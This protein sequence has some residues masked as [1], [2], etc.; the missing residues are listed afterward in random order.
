V[1]TNLEESNLMLELGIRCIRLIRL[2]GEMVEQM[3]TSQ[4]GFRLRDELGSFHRLA[5]PEGCA[6]DCDSDALCF[7]GIGWVLVIWRES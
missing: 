6:V 1:V 4:I 3:S 7:T 2:Q 5:I